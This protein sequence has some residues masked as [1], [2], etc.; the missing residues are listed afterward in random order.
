MLKTFFCFFV[1]C[2]GTLLKRCFFD[3]FSVSETSGSEW[4][5]KMLKSRIMREWGFGMGFFIYIIVF[6]LFAE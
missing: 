4:S 5:K 6:Y 2:F 1:G 3:G